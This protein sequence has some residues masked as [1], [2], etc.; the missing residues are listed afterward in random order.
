VHSRKPS[1]F[2]NSNAS[3]KRSTIAL[4]KSSK[5]RPHTTGNKMRY[6]I[7]K[8]PSAVIGATVNLKVLRK[9]E[10]AVLKFNPAQLIVSPDAKKKVLAQSPWENEN[11]TKLVTDTTAWSSPM[12]CKHK[13][14]IILVYL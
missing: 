7:H 8:A 10:S 14:T 2:V 12:P 13:V 1:L 9:S 11:T 6:S 5:N 3:P 4:A